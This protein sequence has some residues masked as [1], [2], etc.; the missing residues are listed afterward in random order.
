M[1]GDGTRKTGRWGYGTG[2]TV[3]A[4]VM[5]GGALIA[6]GWGVGRVAIADDLDP[7]TITV[8]LPDTNRNGVPDVFEHE[9]GVPNGGTGD[10]AGQG[11]SP[12]G[13][14]V[15]QPVA[16]WTYVIQPGDTLSAISGRTG[17][18]IDI[19]ARANGI[20]DYNLIYAGAALTIPLVA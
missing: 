9:N 5:I 7:G 14:G 19:L 1:S 3:A 6:A 16:P 11:R 20:V 13:D 10:Q 2:P 8:E 15:D 4:T 17:V 12:A 18:P